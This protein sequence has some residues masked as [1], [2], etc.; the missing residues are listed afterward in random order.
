MNPRHVLI[1]LLLLAIAVMLF[2]CRAT[3]TLDEGEYLH[4]RNSVDF[5]PENPGISSGEILTIVKP[6]PNKRFLGIF[7]I[8]VSLYNVG[9][10]GKED[11]KF[12][13]WLREKAGERPVVYD[14]ADV[15]KSVSAVEQYLDKTGYFHSD[16]RAITDFKRKKAYVTYRI[17]PSKPY[18]IANFRLKTDNEELE[19]YIRPVL[20]E[21][22]IDSGSIFNVFT[23]EDE[24]ERV[25][26]RLRN[27]GYYL[28]TPNFVY[29]EVDSSL[30][31]RRMEV[32]MKI[33]NN[34]V[35]SEEDPGKM[36]KIEHK[37]YF[38]DDI[39]INTDFDPTEASVP[40]DTLVMD[41]YRERQDVTNTYHILY[42]DKLK[43]NPK[44]LTQS[45][46]ISPGEA[47]H[48]TDIRKTRQRLNDLGLFNYTNISF[49][50][51]G[52]AG[53]DSLQSR[54]LLD[55]EIDLMKRK[56]HSFTIETEGTNKSG[57]LGA[58]AIFTYQNN[59]FFG[60]SEI[61]RFRVNGALEFQTA[62]SSSSEVS[63]SNRLISTIEAGGEVSISFPKFLIPI[64]QERFPK[65]FRPKTVVRLGINYE[66]RPEYI[67]VINNLRFGYEWRE[68]ETKFHE[69][70]PL[71]LNFV[72]VNLDPE[73]AE[74]VEEEPNDRIRNQYTD[75]M[76]LGLTYSYIINT[77]R[78]QKFQNFF[79]LRANIE[80]AGNLLQLAN[81]AFG[82][83]QDTLDYYTLFNVR[84]SQYIRTDA[85]FRYYF[86]L[87]EENT[88]AT[89]LY[90]GIGIPYG[91]AGVLPLEKGF[92]G[93]GA[94]GIRA[95]ALRLLGP[96]SYSSTDDVF[97]RMGDMHIETNIEYRFPIYQFF[98]GAFFIDIGNV[99][100]LKENSTYPGGEFRF[101]N[102]YKEL[103]VGSGL[104]ARF[105]FNF[106]VFRLD[107]AVKTRDPARPE[108]DRWTFSD[109]R[110]KY[111]LV[112]F[113]IGYPF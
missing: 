65:Y 75:H 50:D 108:G 112:N 16:V 55:C 92:Y 49:R 87:D 63:T 48:E 13:R 46:F 72:R 70:Y 103:A 26:E 4:R 19:S 68:S 111:V 45:V 2:S 82:K 53:T 3:R 83:K 61:F 25:S 102:F 104:G 21:T 37:R 32:T 101:G 73:F 64:K 89:R 10:R 88:I 86:I 17:F 34:L 18:R 67:R 42:E 98:K 56:L 29:Y 31:S 84:Y 91:N 23:L 99:W 12:R 85:D 107:F 38:I 5:Q 69:L 24:R 110:W 43:V 62:L 97:D 28:F 80:P 33:K 36:K 96:G 41:V 35:Y 60:G 74:I 71:D 90:F 105:D 58:G 30:G 22:P 39:F 57:R 7:P 78:L 113:A 76:I 20:E 11:S 47:F 6:K 100:L 94:N 54:P 1:P 59:N 52:F 95:W 109:F 15:N 106:F 14:S 9:T 44:I 40:E 79:Y 81:T 66:D 93:G 27:E 8:Q 51:A 77:Q